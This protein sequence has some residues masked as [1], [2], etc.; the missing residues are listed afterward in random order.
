MQFLKFI[1]S[2][3]LISIVIISEYVFGFW[4]STAGIIG[5]VAAYY[6]SSSNTVG[7]GLPMYR[8]QATGTEGT[9]AQANWGVTTRFFNWGATSFLSG[10]AGST[11]TYVVPNAGYVS[12]QVPPYSRGLFQAAN[13]LNFLGNQNLTRDINKN[14]AIPIAELRLTSYNQDTTWQPG[15]NTIW[16]GGSISGPTPYIYATSSRFNNFDEITLGGNTYM[17][18]NFNNNHLALAPTP[19]YTSNMLILER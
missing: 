8:Q 3:L 19:Q 16:S 13:I 7:F 1:I 18:I 10:T 5:T 9:T 14:P 15:A 2:I 12:N 6:T 17:V 11:T 4:V